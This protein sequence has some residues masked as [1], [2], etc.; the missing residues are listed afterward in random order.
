MIDAVVFLIVLIILGWAVFL[1][2]LGVAIIVG[3]FKGVRD[4]DRAD[5]LARMDAQRARFKARS[6]AGETRSF[7]PRIIA[8]DEADFN[9]ARWEAHKRDAGIGAYRRAQDRANEGAQE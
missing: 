2:F 8:N 7:A 6:E 3:V 1:S 9:W 4:R 5:E